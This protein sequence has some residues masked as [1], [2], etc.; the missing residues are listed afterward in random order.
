MP[1]GGGALGL[2]FLASTLC[3]GLHHENTICILPS[4][5]SH[6]YTYNILKELEKHTAPMPRR[7]VPIPNGVPTQSIGGRLEL[8]I[9]GSRH[10]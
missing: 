6:N 5:V 4:Y 7:T 3:R 2:W 9:S 8:G 1:P 10:G